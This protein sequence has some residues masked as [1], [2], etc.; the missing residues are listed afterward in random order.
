MI[1]TEK[2]KNKIIYKFILVLT[3]TIC[4]INKKLIIRAGNLKHK[5][6][7]KMRKLKNKY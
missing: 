4:K 6:S 2:I 3:H 1:K 7:F 5:Q